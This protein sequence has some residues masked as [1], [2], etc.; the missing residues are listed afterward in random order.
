MA[1]PLKRSDYNANKSLNQEFGGES[2]DPPESYFIRYYSTSLTAAGVGSELSVDGYAPVEVENND[3]N[4]PTTSS[5]LK[6]LAV[7]IESD[8]IE[9]DA[10]IRAVGFWDAETSGNLHYFASFPTSPINISE[11]QT[12]LIKAGNLVIPR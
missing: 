4:F 7:D 2:N 3:T 9:E 1:I 8:V 10:E 5:R 12:I 6:T 11:G